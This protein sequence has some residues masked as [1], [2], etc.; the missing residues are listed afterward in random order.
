MARGRNKQQRFL[1]LLV[2]G[3]LVAPLAHADGPALN[4][5]TLGVSESI[6][7]YCGPLD[8]AAAAKLRAKIK[9]LVRGASE[10]QLAQM[11]NS[12]EYRQAYDS[13]VD[14]VA[15]VD[16][17]NAKRICFEFPAERK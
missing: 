7:N 8:P 10:Q 1:A 16:V 3:W 15:K 11:R 17:H 9:Q 13:L 5:Q 4:A 14:F 6:L 12:D 2:C